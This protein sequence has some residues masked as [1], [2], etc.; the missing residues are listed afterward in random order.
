MGCG[1][2]LDLA[3]AK[4][5]CL[6]LR[7]GLYIPTNGIYTLNLQIPKPSLALVIAQGLHAH[8]RGMHCKWI[9]LRNRGRFP[10]FTTFGVFLF[11]LHVSQCTC[12]S[13]HVGPSRSI[14]GTVYSA[15]MAKMH[16]PVCTLCSLLNPTHLGP[17]S[18]RLLWF[19]SFLLH[20]L[21]PSIVS[22]SQL[23]QHPLLPLL[24]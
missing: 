22:W 2:A 14:M 10:D 3:V 23:L 13:T 19:A 12:L 20:G 18:L 7:V 17:T 5:C 9:E 6:I 24:V 11:A 4:W 21:C 8:S 16:P 1:A 15:L